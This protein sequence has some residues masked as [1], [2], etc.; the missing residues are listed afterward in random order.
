M[1]GPAR[2]QLPRR[3]RQRGEHVTSCADDWGHGDAHHFRCNEGRNVESPRACP[4]V[5]R[6]DIELRDKQTSKKDAFNQLLEPPVPLVPLCPVENKSTS[7]RVLPG[8]SPTGVRARGFWL[9]FQYL[10]IATLTRWVIE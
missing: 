7:Q 3:V 9:G 4:V 10:A 5:S 1:L 6:R 2:S 8:F